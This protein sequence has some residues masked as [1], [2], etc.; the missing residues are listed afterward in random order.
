MEIIRY[1]AEDASLCEKDA[2]ECYDRIVPVILE[3]ALLRL[4]LPI[5]L[6]RF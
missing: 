6:V 1:Y 4:G 2:A 5:A 3:Y